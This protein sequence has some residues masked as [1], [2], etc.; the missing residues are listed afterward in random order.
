MR[1]TIKVIAFLSFYRSLSKFRVVS[2]SSL[3]TW[4]QWTICCFETQV[5]GKNPILQT[6]KLGI[7]DICA[8]KIGINSDEME[9]LI[10]SNTFFRFYCMKKQ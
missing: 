9:V 2:L 8:V 4:K 10:Y 6:L 5:P 1:P 7:F 3:N